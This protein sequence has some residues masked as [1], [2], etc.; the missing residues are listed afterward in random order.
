MAVE[1]FDKLKVTGDGRI[2]RAIVDT[3]EPP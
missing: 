3:D 1:L 2:A